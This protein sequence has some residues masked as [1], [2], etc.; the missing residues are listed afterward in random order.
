MLFSEKDLSA[1]S[2]CASL[3]VNTATVYPARHDELY[4]GYATK[5]HTSW[6]ATESL[7][8]FQLV[9]M[10]SSLSTG[11]RETHHHQPA[12]KASRHND[13]RPAHRDSPET[14][15]WHGN[16]RRRAAGGRPA[17]SVAF[18]KS[19][20]D[21]PGCATGDQL[22]ISDGP[23]MSDLNTKARA[24]SAVPICIIESQGGCIPAQVRS[25]RRAISVRGRVR[26]HSERDPASISH[27]LNSARRETATCKC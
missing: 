14:A 6:I 3:D 24:C 15:P 25:L 18:C 2:C 8:A 12:P 1:R 26:D 10:L 21:V 19:I 20:L 16:V 7:V 23:Q 4:Q 5:R 17:S 27:F 9:M 11:R 13:Q 22:A